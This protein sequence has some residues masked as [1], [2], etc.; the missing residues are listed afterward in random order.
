MPVVAIDLSPPSTVR[1]DTVLCGN[2]VAKILWQVD[3]TVLRY[4]SFRC[5]NRSDLS[6]SDRTAEIWANLPHCSSS[7]FCS[8]QEGI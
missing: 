5:S 8:L 4:C 2:T 3:V 7:Q 1:Q 6:N